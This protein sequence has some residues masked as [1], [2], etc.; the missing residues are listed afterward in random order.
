MGTIQLP[1]GTGTLKFRAQRFN[2]ESAIDLRRL[3][4]RLE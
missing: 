1:K 4:F 3:T 2:G